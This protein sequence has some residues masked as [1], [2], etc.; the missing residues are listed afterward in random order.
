[1]ITNEQFEEAAK[2]IGVEPAAL[3]AVQQIETGGKGGFLTNGKPQILFEGHIFWSELKKR[4]LD[5]NKFVKGNEDILY[6]KWDKTKY[7]GGLKEWDRLYK[8]IQ[9]HR[10]AA[11]SSASW[12]MFQIMGFN[13]KTCGCLNV[14]SFVDKMCESEFQQLL[15]SVNFIKNNTKIVNAL[16]AKDWS[17]FAYYYNGAGY[18][19]NKYDTK[20]KAAYEKYA[21]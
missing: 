2:L 7:K 1:M 5:P 15:L 18:A 16:R 6:P 12:G 14:S 20:L 19:Q 4:G 11:L 17:K 9:I 10:E 13:Y 8:A 3:K 21:K